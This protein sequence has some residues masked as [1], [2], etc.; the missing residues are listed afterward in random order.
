M[1]AIDDESKRIFDV[2]KTKVH[3]DLDSLTQLMNNFKQKMEVAP[4]MKWGQSETEVHIFLKLSHRFDS[5][6]CLDL[7]KEPEMSFENNEL[8]F[9]AECVQASYP[10]IFVLDFEVFGQVEKAKLEKMSI[11]NY[12]LILSKTDSL[13]W[14]DL[15]RVFDD[16]N[17]FTI[18]IWYELED[19]YPY[20]M[21]AFY[22]KMEKY[23][24]L[25]KEEKKKKAIKLAAESCTS[26]LK[27]FLGE[28]REGIKVRYCFRKKKESKSE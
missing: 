19:R 26:H 13:I 4:V 1:Y 3:R 24:K 7:L 5:P 15:F 18:K 8:H 2:F 21:E 28:L 6:G 22:T 9:K 10:L 16:R 14:D 23:F 17:R 12:R 25:K 20:A 27:Q 11:G